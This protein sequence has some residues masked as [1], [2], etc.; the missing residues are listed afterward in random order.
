M[1]KTRSMI[2]NRKIFDK[3]ST[4]F[5]VKSES[6]WRHYKNRV[7]EGAGAISAMSMYKGPAY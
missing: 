3:K 4:V 7:D 2:D 5:I 1:V 6:R